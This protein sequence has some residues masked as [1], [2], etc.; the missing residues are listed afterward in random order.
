MSIKMDTVKHAA[1]IARID[2]NEE[3]AMALRVKFDSIIDLVEEMNRLDLSDVPPTVTGVPEG[4][5]MR[6]DVLEGRD[7]T[8]DL[9][10]NAPASKGLFFVCPRIVE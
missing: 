2:V 4:A 1:M 6:D 10:S 5:R 8:S 3:E 7:Y 9:L